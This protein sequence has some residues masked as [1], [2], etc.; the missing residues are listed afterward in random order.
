MSKNIQEVRDGY[1][2]KCSCL[3]LAQL[4]LVGFSRD[5][6]AS[7][8]AADGGTGSGW[9][10]SISYDNEQEGVLAGLSFTS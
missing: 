7:E 9:K 10:F 2:G 4:T 8:A 3:L 6:L 1:K 5:A